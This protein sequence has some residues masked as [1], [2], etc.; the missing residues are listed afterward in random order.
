MA[1]KRTPKF[2][3]P[4]WRK[5]YGPG[6]TKRKNK[7]KRKSAKRKP[8]KKKTTKRKTG[9]ARILKNPPR[10]WKNVNQIRVVKGKNGNDVLYVR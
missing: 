4:A 3:S 10:T 7:A 8:A 9:K 5:L 1:K 6:G 2:G